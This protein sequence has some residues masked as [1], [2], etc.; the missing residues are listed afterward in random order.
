MVGITRLIQLLL[1]AGCEEA[2]AERF[3]D[4]ARRELEHIR[5]FVIMHY[6]LTQ[7]DNSPFW[8]RCRNMS[9]PDSLAERI[10]LFE[11]RP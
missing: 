5:D 7:R 9:I 6:K 3:N 8:H 1:F 10:A 2:L 11:E 4:Q